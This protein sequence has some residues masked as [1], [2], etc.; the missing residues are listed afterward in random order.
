M[1]RCGR[2]VC[3]ALRVAPDVLLR[4]PQTPAASCRDPSY[5]QPAGAPC[6]ADCDCAY[7]SPPLSCLGW[8]D[9]AGA[10][11]ACGRPCEYDRQCPG[12]QICGAAAGDSPP[13]GCVA[14]QRD[15]CV[16]HA[17]CPPGFACELGPGGL[18]DCVDQRLRDHGGTACT[19][20]ADCPPGLLCTRL[21]GAVG[22]PQGSEPRC[23]AP[24]Q[25]VSVPSADC[26]GMGIATYCLGGLCGSTE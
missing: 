5:D 19:C 21:L 9:A 7:S 20:D 26:A 22:L 4:Y 12:G 24:C 2:R 11:A 1:R 18:N 17:D 23:Q 6:T 13:P 3:G 15:A 14:A 16:T 25:D 8:T 10:H